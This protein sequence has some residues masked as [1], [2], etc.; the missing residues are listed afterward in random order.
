[1]L[2]MMSIALAWVFWQWYNDRPSRTH[3]F[4]VVVNQGQKQSGQ[5]DNL[6]IAPLRF[7]SSFPKAL[8]RIGSA[9][10]VH[11]TDE[12]SLDAQ[13]IQERLSSI[14][15]LS[16]PQD[17]L[18]CSIQSQCMTIDGEARLIDADFSLRDSSEDSRLVASGGIA[19]S[20]LLKYFDVF[21]GTVLLALDAGDVVAD[22]AAHCEQ[23]DFL[24][25]LQQVAKENKNDRLWILTSH[26]P[27][28]ISQ[29]DLV[30]RERLFG[31]A[32]AE[33]LLGD[34]RVPNKEE[35]LS[36][37]SYDRILT[38]D[39]LANYVYRR[40]HS[41]S[42]KSQSPW[43]IRS[44]EGLVRSDKAGWA[45]ART[46]HLAKLDKQGRILGVATPNTSESEKKPDVAVAPSTQEKMPTDPWIANWQEFEK[47]WN[48]KSLD[49]SYAW[50]HAECFPLVFRKM[51]A[52]LADAELRGRAGLSDSLRWSMTAPS[53]PN[54]S[55]LQRLREL[56]ESNAGQKRWDAIEL[57]DKQEQIQLLQQVSQASLHVA[58]IRQ[59]VTRLDALGEKSRPQLNGLLDSFDHRLATS[60]LRIRLN[61]VLG[62]LKGT[63]NTLIDDSIGDPKTAVLES[64]LLCGSLTAE[65]REKV[66]NKKLAQRSLG[67][68]YPTS[69][70]EAPLS[71]NKPLKSSAGNPNATAPSN[72]FSEEGKSLQSAIAN[73]VKQGLRDDRLV[74]RADQSLSLI[75][76]LASLPPLPDRKHG[77]WHDWQQKGTPIAQPLRLEASKRLSLSL[78]LDP[79]PKPSEIR[80]QR[81]SLP[82][83]LTGLKLDGER[84]DDAN[85]TF[86]RKWS[87]IEQNG[88]SI[89]VELETSEIARP[90]AETL[91]LKISG[92][93]GPT[94]EPLPL[95]LRLTS[96][97]RIELNV[98]RL[99]RKDGKDEWWP[100][101]ASIKGKVFRLHP[102]AGH[103]TL[104]S[105]EAL[106]RGEAAKTI[107]ADL[108]SLP[109]RTGV[110]GILVSSDGY[111]QSDFNEDS[112]VR[113]V[114][115]SAAIATAKGLELKP[116]QLQKMVLLPAAAAPGTEVPK[117][118]AVTI[119]PNVSAGMVLILTDV[120][121]GALLESF[122]FDY[123]PSKP[124]EYIEAYATVEASEQSRVIAL[125]AQYRDANED[126]VPDLSPTDNQIVDVSIFRETWMGASPK[127]EFNGVIDPSRKLPLKLN[128]QV[129]TDAT[130]E[131]QTFLSLDIGGYPRALSKNISLRDL[132]KQVLESF[133]G[134]KPRSAIRAISDGT[135]TYWA[136]MPLEQKPDADFPL[137][138]KSLAIFKQ[139][140]QVEVKIALDWARDVLNGQVQSAFVRLGDTEKKIFGDRNWVFQA[141]KLTEEG[142]A[143]TA[144]ASD[145]S[146]E[147]D[148][149]GMQN[150]TLPLRTIAME[151]ESNTVEVVF[152]SQLPQLRI[153]KLLKEDVFKGEETS[154][155]F[156]IQENGLSGFSGFD[157]LVHNN[158]NEEKV[159]LPGTLS[160]IE[161]ERG[162]RSIERKLPIGK[163]ESGSYKVSIS[164]SDLAG[165]GPAKSNSVPLRIRER[166]APLAEGKAS[167]K[168][169]P[170]VLGNIRGKVR[171]ANGDE[172]SQAK[173]AIDSNGKSGEFPN[174]NFSFS[175]VPLGKYKITAEFPYQS[176]NWVGEA[177][178]VF[179]TEADFQKEIEIKCKKAP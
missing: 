69:I 174:G 99:I 106:N 179:K 49:A 10:I 156:E 105:F 53:D 135:K 144:I 96:M 88:Q 60:D 178:G 31:R 66:L 80:I 151:R 141:T 138:S 131:N 153:T 143:I 41:D 133:R 63:M 100:E 137:G 177:T 171:F 168:N 158:L 159:R 2:C 112:I 52:Q 34:V 165:N 113:Q 38:L 39:E 152:D 157:M 167:A 127:G 62:N 7:T 121:N 101:E 173:V 155:Q 175:E 147:I 93:N 86:V 116:Q 26:S 95:R 29:D 172:P 132:Q 85:P 20:Q 27:G 77:W 140:K 117:S 54:P 8:S 166:P 104:F 111:I 115:K 145:H 23:N 129:P 58:E 11:V 37:W 15:K 146:I 50:S 123:D 71:W 82:D 110:P 33:A 87:Q 67:G 114:R 119:S 148:S 128:L 160:A 83:G 18:I 124:S 149:S 164:V 109:Y 107:Q 65:Q 163:L 5:L 47:A 92:I 30:G 32:L 57:A 4:S 24:A 170:P 12:L 126:G 51:R 36:Q 76:P 75:T 154:V 17:K 6:S 74:A 122:L 103:E 169:S 120:S 59:L 46:V 40:V 97:D 3:L 108:Y 44:S 25:K 13:K 94:N 162:S 42:G 161:F 98:N 9:S 84:I 22:S 134:E 139:P 142:I 21:P 19:L 73:L 61:S 79:Y 72:A 70:P 14:S 136:V 64:L 1:M 176:S 48:R 89:E 102:F 35:F 43:L 28:E 16:Q 55:D 118:P 45:D 68:E 125:R 91:A 81:S 90:S 130:L 150:K 56:F 78:K